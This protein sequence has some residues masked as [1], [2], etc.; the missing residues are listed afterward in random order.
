MSEKAP[1]TPEEI[2]AQICRIGDK[3][4]QRALQVEG[5]SSHDSTEITIDASDYALTY[6]DDPRVEASPMKSVSVTVHEAPLKTSRRSWDYSNPS[7][8]HGAPDTTNTF[9]SFDGSRDGTDYDSH[10]EGKNVMVQFSDK[11]S[12]SERTR[13]TGKEEAG[14]A[15]LTSRLR[16]AKHVAEAAKTL[17]DIRGHIAAREIEIKQQKSSTESIEVQKD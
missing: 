16:R 5:S 7:A 6:P 13:W 4:L 8:R 15:P 12:H 10:L 9:F 17:M 2:N 1:R 14:D 11:G 3:L